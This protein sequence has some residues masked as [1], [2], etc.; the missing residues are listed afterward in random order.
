MLRPGTIRARI[1]KFPLF[2]LFAFPAHFRSESGP[3]PK[4]RGMRTVA[5]F[6][7]PI[8]RRGDSMRRL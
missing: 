7:S 3:R 4:T 8:A 6:D 1:G 2:P 5:A